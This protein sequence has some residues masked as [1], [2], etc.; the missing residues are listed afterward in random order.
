MLSK[1]IIWIEDDIDIIYPVIEK[2][3]KSGYSIEKMYTIQDAEDSI[4]SLRKA[5]LILLDMIVLPDENQ[6]L[7]TRYPGMEFLNEMR[8]KYKIDTP[9]IVFTV[10]TKSEVRKELMRLGVS[11]IIMKP[12]RSSDLKDRVENVLERYS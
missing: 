8:N 6:R 12:V 11:D 3:E 9:V 4:D 7:A 2:L 5:D 1:K 10:V